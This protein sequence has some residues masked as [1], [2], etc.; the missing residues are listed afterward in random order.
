MNWAIGT[1]SRF[2]STLPK[3]TTVPGCMLCLCVTIFLGSRKGA[4]TK[5]FLARGGKEPSRNSL[6]ES[7]K[8]EALP[9]TRKQRKTKSTHPTTTYS[10]YKISP[11]C[12]FFVLVVVCD[13]RW[14]SDGSGVCREMTR[15][16]FGLFTLWG[17]YEE[18][19]RVLGRLTKVTADFKDN[20]SRVES[21]YVFWSQLR[22]VD[23]S[24]QSSRIL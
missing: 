12:R 1:R 7:R 9:E 19:T 8:H 5:M 14:L 24:G 18:L 6:R 13:G 22:Y 16:N 17:V 10:E 2:D 20:Q 4:T 3:H 21:R 23:L 15:A 11:K